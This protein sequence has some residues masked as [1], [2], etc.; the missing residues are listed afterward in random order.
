V[1]AEQVPRV[2][3]PGRRERILAAAA[4]LIARRSYHAVSMAEIGAAA[5]IV[6]S[7]IYRHFDSKVAV[8]VALLERVMERLLDSVTHAVLDA[9]NDEAAMA[10]LIRDHIDFVIDDRLMVQL[11]QREL[12]T[13]PED[14]RRRLRRMQRLYVEEWV[15]VLAGLRPELSDSHARAL[16]HAAIGAIQS[17]VWFNSGLPRE[18]LT[19]LLGGAAQACLGIAKPAEPSPPWPNPSA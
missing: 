12:L 11:Y 16:V 7:G 17:A 19:H 9:P 1:T 4:E 15:H 10:A 18:E 3:D 6:G 8:L 13:L 14:D 5:G 2:R